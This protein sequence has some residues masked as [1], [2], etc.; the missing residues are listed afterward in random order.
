MSIVAPE[1]KKLPESGAPED[2][3]RS[4]VSAEVA[5][6][7]GLVRAALRDLAP[8]DLDDLTGG[9]E[10]DLAE[11][12]AES[13]EPLIS[14]LG[15][16]SAYAAEL[17]AAAGF[18]PPDVLP[19]APTERWWRRTY[20][21]ASAWWR[22]VLVEHPWVEKLRPVWWLLRGVVLA[23]I[24]FSLMGYSANTVLLLLGAAF[25]FWIGLMQDGWSG[26]RAR[27]IM[28]A[29]VVAAIMFLPVM[30]GMQ[31]F[32]G[33]GY[34]SGPSEYVVEVPPT[35]GVFVG[36]EEVVNLFVYDGSGQRV[37]GARVFTDQGAQVLVQPWVIPAW[38]GTLERE[39]PFDTFP[40]TAGDLDGWSGLTTESGWTP[41][42]LIGPAAG[43]VAPDSEPTDQ[44]TADPTDGA[45]ED[46]GDKG[47][48]D[49][50]DGGNGESTAEPQE[51]PTPT[52]TE[53]SDKDD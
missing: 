34:A 32:L 1:T 39:L 22:T 51:S 7:V 33:W 20:A 40:I 41:P 2:A 47:A 50:E 16:P 3:D 49:G 31:H 11:L 9:L 30:A 29:N 25:S 23:A 24:I 8:E 21:S 15:E 17:R 10:A 4:R 53:R 19:P 43:F 6:Y 26:W 52:S 48:E 18:P 13:E 35:E 42:I 28:I 45:T 12:A 38:E 37:E 14:R 5:A 36:G 44:S 27:A 46:S